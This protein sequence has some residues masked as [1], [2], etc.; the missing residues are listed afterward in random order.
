MFWFVDAFHHSL[1]SGRE[2]L[3]PLKAGEVEATAFAGGDLAI[4]DKVFALLRGSLLLARMSSRSDSIS[5]EG[6][7]LR[8]MFSLM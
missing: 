3:R 4:D 5:R 8:M 2:A 1:A 6:G 7:A